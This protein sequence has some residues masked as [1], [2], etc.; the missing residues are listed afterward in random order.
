[1]MDYLAGR[2]RHR[3]DAGGLAALER[4]C[5]AIE[6]EVSVL[7]TIYDEHAG[8]QDRFLTHRARDAGARG[9]LGLTGLAGARQRP[10][11]GPALDHPWPPYDRS[12]C[13]WRRIAPATS[14]RA[15]RCASTR[16]SNRCASSGPCAPACR[17]AS[18][19]RRSACPPAAALGAG[20]VEGW[21]GEVLVALE[22]ARR[23]GP[24]PPLPLPRPLLA[25]LARA[26]AC[27]DRQHR[28]GLLSSSAPPAA[29]RPPVSAS[30]RSLRSTTRA[31][32]ARCATSRDS[33]KTTIASGR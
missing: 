16:S 19:Q 13:R 21:R 29:T 5:D 8:L 11:D 28:S 15:S 12:R 31:S 25:E 9:Q 33:P 3:P 14:R 2:R 20:W 26:R 27:R 30:S 10:V 23:Q 32:C 17:R 7:R 6:R 18:S 22:L 1:M 24:D 4:Q